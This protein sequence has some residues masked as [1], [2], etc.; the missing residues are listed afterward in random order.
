[1]STSSFVPTRKHAGVW[2]QEYFGLYQP[3][4][5]E[6]LA[7][8]RSLMS[9][10]FV[11]ADVDDVFPHFDEL[12]GVTRLAGLGGLHQALFDA[13]QRMVRVRAGLQDEVN[14]ITVMTVDESSDHQFNAEQL[15]MASDLWRNGRTYGESVI[16]APGATPGGGGGFA[17]QHPVVQ[18]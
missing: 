9:A 11:I 16:L 8:Q 4:I 12:R 2:A 10:P 6:Q 15:A 14:T 7:V 13:H 18:R 1:M 5:V 17:Q 3:S